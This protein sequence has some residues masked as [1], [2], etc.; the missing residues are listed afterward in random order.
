MVGC[1]HTNNSWVKKDL[2][3]FLHKIGCLGSM[4]ENCLEFIPLSF[5]PT[6]GD[7]QHIRIRGGGQSKKFS[8]NPKISLQVQYN[9]KISAHF[10]YINLYMNIKYPQT[11]QIEV[12]IASIEPRNI[13]ITMFGIKKY[14][15]HSFS[16][17]WTQKYHF[18]QHSDP[19]I[20]DL[21]PR[22]ACAECPH[23]GLSND[24]ATHIYQEKFD[25][26]VAMAVNGP[27][28]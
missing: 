17:L 21:P 23:P 15:E 10:I 24:F 3:K 9:P 25:A 12:R 14:H 16:S 28:N 13:N 1:C 19:K 26:K 18:W 5:F 20:S 2:S 8:S 22:C 27:S 6:Q 11:M 4:L 7:T